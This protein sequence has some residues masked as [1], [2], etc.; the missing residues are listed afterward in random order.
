[1]NGKE[2]HADAGGK[3]IKKL[4]TGDKASTGVKEL[5]LVSP[6]AR[7][8]VNKEEIQDM[9]LSVGCCGIMYKG[10][11]FSNAHGTQVIPHCC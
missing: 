11:I 3:K 6:R 4:L 9:L 1:M 10:M 2:G 7:R 5:S 8:L